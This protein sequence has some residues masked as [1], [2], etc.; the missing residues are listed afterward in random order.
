MGLC[1]AHKYV[2]RAAIIRGGLEP[3]N[4]LQKFEFFRCPT[5]ARVEAFRCPR[6]DFDPRKNTIRLRRRVEAEVESA[7]GRKKTLRVSFPDFEL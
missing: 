5:L 3:E 6:A 7:S 1:L 4:V 2:A